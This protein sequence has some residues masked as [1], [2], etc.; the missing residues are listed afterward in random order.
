MNYRNYKYIN[1]ETLFAEIKTELSSYFNSGAVNEVMFPTYVNQALRKLKYL[2]LKPESVVL[3]FVDYKSNLPEDFCLLDYAITYEFANELSG[4]VP[5]T[6]GYYS[7]Q[8]ECIGRCDSSCFPDCDPKY[9]VFEKIT[10]PSQIGINRIQLTKPAWVRVYY[11]SS[12]FCESNC[13]NLTK[14]SA[15]VITIQ[16]AGKVVSNFSKGCIFMRYFAKPTD[17]D[18]TPLIP[19]QLEIEEYIKSHIK[20]KLFEQLFNS[21]VDET[22]NQIQTKFNFYKSDSLNKLQ[23]AWSILQ[24]TKQQSA[25]SVARIRG[26]YKRFDIH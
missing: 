23:A 4:S 2:S 7:K 18:G 12:E 24:P 13:P 21:V 5:T 20:F 16:D 8:I 6:T 22:F 3:H 17:D 1:P 19:E 10:I 14:K 15:N 26:R 25:D 9:E 11:G